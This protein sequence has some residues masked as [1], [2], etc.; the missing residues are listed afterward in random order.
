MNLIVAF[1]TFAFNAVGMFLLVS[2]SE[3]IAAAV[4]GVNTRAKIYSFLWILVS[5]ISIAYGGMYFIVWMVLEYMAIL[6][7]YGR[8]KKD[9]LENVIRGIL[10]LVVMS[11]TELSIILLYY[12][13]DIV[14]L[15]YSGK[16][17]FETQ[18]ACSVGTALIQQPAIVF[19][20]IRQTRKGSR[21]VL[22]YILAV[23][24]IADI[25]WFYTCAAMSFLNQSCITSGLFAVE[26]VF[27]YTFFFI[28]AFRI[29]ERTEQDI[30]AQINSNA[31]EYYLNMEEEH[32][33]IRKMYHEMKNQL[34]IMENGGEDQNGHKSD[35]SHT[36]Q[37][38]LE[39]LN[40]FYHTGQPSLDM[41][42]FDG[43][44]KAK[45]RN[46]EFDAVVS[47]G[48]LDF[49]NKEDINMI[50][51]NAIINAIEACEKIKEGPRQIRIKA[52]KN[53]ND[54]LV[55]VKNTVSH[56]REKGSLSTKKKNRI[57]HGIGLTSIQECA[58][59]YGGY[60]SIIEEE[61]TFQLAI[62]FG[63]E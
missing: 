6:C 23:K 33:Q 37:K 56:E 9:H 19:R 60:V 52:G 20:Y 38:K 8:H 1:L 40:H 15:K 27:N 34:M 22:M 30:R 36:A 29:E 26:I 48:C 25:V 39:D 57:E 61:G 45:A 59:K 41:L 55:Y 50:F 46:I 16:V 42:L 4:D 43:E 11:M 3:T 7:W 10:A 62:L 18:I 44:M 14:N 12:H 32:L 47:E 5:V 35:Y 63:K 53:L 28:L 21:K 24:E 54:T 31:Y 58:E 49:M 17:D 2:N 13:N 51:G